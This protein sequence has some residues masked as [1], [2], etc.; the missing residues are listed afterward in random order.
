MGFSHP[1]RART[2]A[3][4]PTSIP[5]HRPQPD[6]QSHRKPREILLSKTRKEYFSLPTRLT[7][8]LHQ[9][10]CAALQL[11]W[12]SKCP[13]SASVP[14]EQG[15]KPAHTA[16]RRF[17]GIS[18]AAGNGFLIL[19][20]LRDSPALFSSS[21]SHGMMWHARSLGWRAQGRSELWDSGFMYA[22]K[23][24]YLFCFSPSV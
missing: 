19:T 24:S 21:R 17:T 8:G 14:R 23:V 2:K 12:V 20:L 11:S 1:F 10:Y 4:A 3:V 6:M 22:Q 13:E 7:A 15:I 5:R 18:L 9:L 16:G